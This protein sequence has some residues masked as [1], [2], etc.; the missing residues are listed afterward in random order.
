MLG[1]QPHEMEACLDTEVPR[2]GNCRRLGFCATA[3]LLAA[4]VIVGTSMWPSS[5]VLQPAQHGLVD[6]V[7]LYGRAFAGTYNT[8]FSTT[9]LSG[10]L[11]KL[12]DDASDGGH[13]VG[14][15]AVLEAEKQI[16]EAMQGDCTNKRYSQCGG[17]DWWHGPSCCPP[18]SACERQNQWYSQCI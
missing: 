5:R 14:H 9:P 8:G 15:H 2:G 7:V 4:T 16:K 10:P 17:G 13:Y 1:A 18:G 11:A 3:V 6:G 12:I